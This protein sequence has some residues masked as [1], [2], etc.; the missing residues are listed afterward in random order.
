[1]NSDN[2]GI[3]NHD[4]RLP[5]GHIYTGFAYLNQIL[6]DAALQIIHNKDVPLTNAKIMRMIYIHMTDVLP[7]YQLYELFLYRQTS[8]H[9]HVYL[10]MHMHTQN[11]RKETDAIMYITFS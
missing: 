7:L 6:T 4:V 1:M 10:Y 3:F 8:T 5:K 2:W 11:Y 9:T